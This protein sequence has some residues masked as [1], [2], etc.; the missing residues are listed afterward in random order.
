[1]G[2]GRTLG[3]YRKTEIST[4]GK[5]DLVVMCYDKSIQFIKQAKAECAQGA[6]E[7]KARLLQKTLDI[8]NE[9]QSA[10]D[11]NKGGEIARNLDAIYSYLTRRLIRGDV[12]KDDSAFD[13]TVRL[14]SDLKEA[15]EGIA[16]DEKSQKIP[17]VFME[18]PRS[19]SAQI[20]A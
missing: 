4:A 14:L 2:Y 1:M 8:I 20:T 10:L 9:L 6:F 16:Y 11:F 18:G 15:W 5:M 19:L 3:R 7:K 12:E 17:N 13:E